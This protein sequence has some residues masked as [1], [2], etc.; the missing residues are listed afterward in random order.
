M[1]LRKFDTGW[2][3][4]MMP[5]PAVGMTELTYRNNIHLNLQLARLVSQ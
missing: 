4:E 1:V 3:A 5:K 2:S